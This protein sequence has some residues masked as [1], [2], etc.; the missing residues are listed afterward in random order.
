MVIILLDM[1][2]QLQAI[3]WKN[4]LLKKSHLFSS[5]AEIGLP[6]GFM[7]LLILI[8]SITSVSD[9]PN[10]SYSCGQTYPWYYDNDNA[11][12]L[13][14]CVVKPPECTS[15]KYYRHGTL[16]SDTNSAMDG[17]MVYS[18]LGYV[19][20]AASSGITENP[21]Y[22]F[23]VGD[24]SG[25]YDYT[26]P[27]PAENPS[28]DIADILGLLDLHDTILG[29]APLNDDPVLTEYSHYLADYI[30]VK[31]GSGAD[32][33]ATV[34]TFATQGAMEDYMTDRHYDDDDYA[35]GKIAMAVVLNSVDKDN[36]HWDY[37]IRT[38][39]TDMFSLDQPTVACLYFYW[40]DS[41][42]LTYTIPSTKFYV[43][44][45][46]KPQLVDSLF[47]YSYSGFLTLQEI[48]DNFI[49]DQYSGAGGVDMHASLSFMPTQDFVTDDFQYVISS[50]LGLFYMLSYLYPV[51]RMVRSLV[52]EKENR[53]KEGMKMM[54]LTDFS[55]NLSWAIT[56]I[57]QMTIVS[58]LIT[59]VTADSVFEYSDKLYVFIYFEI[60]SL[61]VI[62][63]C[64]L[65][66]TLFSKSKTASLV[67]P[68]VFFASY[69][70]FYVV[71]N[72]QIATS[73]KSAACL[74]AP[75]C[76][77]LG[78]TV[79]A[80]F[81]GGL[82]GV[83]SSN[84]DDSTSNFSYNLCIGMLTF[85]VFLYGF[86]AW[87]ADKIFPS[88][89]GTQL[90]WYFPILPSYWCGVKLK[91]FQSKSE[92]ETA[93]L[94]MDDE[95]PEEDCGE[96]HVAASAAAV[97]VETGRESLYNKMQNSNI[98]YEALSTN[99]KQL[100]R[101][102]KAVKLRGLRKVFQTTAEDRVAVDSLNL[103]MYEGQVTV[104]LGH[105]GAGKS[106]TISMM[107]GLIPP[108]AGDGF[109]YGNS[110]SSDMS[111]IRKVLG[112]CPQH[113]ILFPE[114]T[115]KQHLQM[116]AVFKGVP[117]DQVDGAV[118][119]MIAEVGLN[120]KVHALSATLS[121]GQKRK[122]SLGIALIGDSKIV[123]LDEPTSGMDP[124]SRR[125]TWNIIQ[126]NKKGRIILLTTH[127]MDEADILGDRIAIMADGKL[128]CVGSPM[129]LKKQYGVGYTFTIVKDTKTIAALPL[130]EKSKINSDI[131]DIVSKHVKDSEPLACVGAEA[132]FRLP[133][134]ASSSFV[135]LFR[136]LDVKKSSLYLAQYGISVTTL[137]EVFI[138]VAEKTDEDIVARNSGLSIDF[139]EQGGKKS[140]A[141]LSKASVATVV[142]AE[143]VAGV[144]SVESGEQ[145]EQGM[146]V[147]KQGY[148]A[149]NA[150]EK[151]AGDSEGEY[152]CIEDDT[153][154]VV[155][156][157]H[158]RAL[159]T[160]R[161]IYGKRDK[162][163]FCCQLLLPVMLV[164][165]GLGIL[166]LIPNLTQP[167]LIL[168]PLHFNPDYDAPEQNFVPFSTL[169]SEFAQ[170]IFDRFNGQP[171]ATASPE[172]GVW[173][174]AVEVN[175]SIE[176]QFQGCAQGAA[177]LVEMGNFLIGETDAQKDNER[178]ST[179][180]GA[181]TVSADSSP[182]SL[183]YNIMVNGSALHGPGIFM[184]LVDQAFLQVVTGN[185]QATIVAHNYPLPRTFDQDRFNATQSALTA[186]F[187]FMIAF[188]FIPASFATFIVKE[189]EIKAKHQQIISGVSLYAYWCSSFVWDV[190]SYMLTYVLV[191]A[192]LF[193]YELDA[194]TKNDSGVATALVFFLYGP[195]IASFT[196]LMSFGFQSH[197]TA[198][199][200]VMFFN[201]VTGLC[202]MIV[203]FILAAIPSSQEVA[204]PLRYMFRVFPS[205][206]LGDA[207]AMLSMCTVSGKFFVCL[208]ICVISICSCDICHVS[209]SP[210]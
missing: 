188:S 196:Y 176:D 98:K 11:E 150:G 141:D 173:G 157:K 164:V 90:P 35:M 202:L 165:F 110:L 79:F 208:G 10:V 6:I 210:Y 82:V 62:N 209:K 113:D 168:S 162:Q 195:A 46:N 175:T 41:C 169:E 130:K 33:N 184:N 76:F 170:E 154:W 107:V 105:N 197:S 187:F 64:F 7:G 8:K 15:D 54:G 57:T 117:S 171:D 199:I 124:Y 140:L 14:Q 22:T 137:E 43:N 111:A 17:T 81:E 25:A 191:I 159:L 93:L 190:T 119:R 99:L 120:E 166:L 83:Q 163:M 115:V 161:A 94:S 80:D 207:L 133:F 55:Y 118:E 70:P 9:A 121:G 51:S 30:R 20:S 69:F 139:G 40:D 59:L 127:F 108:T 28:L 179:R 155:F 45:L 86:L 194:F 36:G 156:G 89:F 136:E 135:K 205:F 61:A 147:G 152:A 158:F 91:D 78:A 104:L 131:S 123:V 109:M 193:A 189:R 174:V 16:I 13:E 31:G 101:E 185:N 2:R 60:F 4:W 49:F 100:G 126:K 58:I 12:K 204:V 138:K 125:S 198:Q 145:L 95:Y 77:A 153:P 29:I 38:N 24:S 206:C 180:Y 68:L 84:L 142:A 63:M 21:L 42:L 37:S 73:S 114:L 116:F 26:Q 87:Y 72:P 23:T 85:D 172:G 3:L 39:Y 47:G 200:M 96:G 178:G 71:D 5:I 67:G 65:M 151:E 129:Y 201:F 19:E 27:Y 74:L 1:F 50:T 177:P 66:A 144:V 97:E 186:A 18:E 183:S 122:L 48:V 52:L 143:D 102:G 112:V 56:L 53:F 88:E 134:E 128:R 92:A 182:S 34:Q 149:V 203:A 75:T 103:D 167:D 181:V 148:M 132:S 146:V 106:T 192:V 160:K 32:S 44:D